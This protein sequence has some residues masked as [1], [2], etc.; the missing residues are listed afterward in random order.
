MFTRRHGYIFKKTWILIAL[1]GEIEAKWG[2]FSVSTSV[3]FSRL[4]FHQ[5]LH[6]RPPAFLWKD[7]G[8]IADCSSTKTYPYP[9]KLRVIKFK[10]GNLHV[11]VCVCV[12]S[13]DRMRNCI[14]CA[15]F[16]VTRILPLVKFTS[17]EINF[18]RREVVNPSALLFASTLSFTTL[19]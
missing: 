16:S 6:I 9:I 18:G 12:L 10:V 15:I 17:S 8:P 2:F 1:P 7:S 4:S 19:G 5:S 13:P 3:F 14:K 11:C